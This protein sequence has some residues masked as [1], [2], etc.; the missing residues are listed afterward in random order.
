MLLKSQWD[1]TTHLPGWIKLSLILSNI[2]DDMKQWEHNGNINWY[3]HFGKQSLSSKA[4]KTLVMT[5]IS[6]LKCIHY[7]CACTRT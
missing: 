4:E 1:T 6:I 7:R 2:W 5:Q 3:S